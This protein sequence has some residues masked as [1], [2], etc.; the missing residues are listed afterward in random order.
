[1]SDSEPER[2]GSKGDGT[3]TDS[4]DDTGGQTAVVTHPLRPTGKRSRRGAVSDAEGV[5]DATTETKAAVTKNGAPT[6]TAKKVAERP[7]RNPLTY[8]WTYLAQ[9]VAELRKVIWPNRKQMVS[10]TTVVLIFLAFMVALIGLV[11]LGLA[12]LVM[13][14]FG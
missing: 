13:Q 7:S 2:T 10:Y 11:D 1:V 12:K 6:K 8:I 3:V 4:T 14:V 5:S 9:V